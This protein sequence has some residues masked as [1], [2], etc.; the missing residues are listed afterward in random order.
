VFDLSY[1]LDAAGRFTEALPYALK[2]AELS[3]T[4]YALDAAAAHYR[5]AGRGVTEDDAATRVVVAEGLGDVLTLQGVYSEAEEQYVL[6]RS[7]VQERAAAASIDAKLGALAFKQADIATARQHLE[8][9]LERLGRRIPRSTPA[10]VL[11]LLWEAMVQAAHS[12]APKLLLGRR[13]PAGREVD[14]LAMRIYSRLAYLYWFYSGRTT[15]AWTHLR[16]LNLAERYPPSPELAQAYS[17]HAPVMTML[18]WFSRGLRYARRS[19]EIRHSYGDTWGKGQSLGFLAVVEYNAS[20]FDDAIASCNEAIRLLRQTGDQWEVNTATWH[21]ALCHWRK[22]ELA[23]AAHVARELFYS[24]REIGDRTAAG[25][26]LSIWTRVSDGHLD[27][28]LLEEQIRASDGD[29]AQTTAELYLA[30]ALHARANGDLQAALD[31]LEQAAGVV[32]SAK[33]RQEYIAP[34]Y[35]WIATVRREL[36]ERAPLH[37]P[38]LRESFLRRA[39]RSARVARRW[40]RSYR[41]N[42][43][44][45]LRESALIASERGRCRRARRWMDASVAV[46]VAQGARYEAAL[47]ESIRAELCASWG[48]SSEVRPHDADSTAPDAVAS[49]SEDDEVPTISLFDRFSALLKAGR[50]ITAAASY[51]ALEAA[52]REA[53]LALLRAERCHLVPLVALAD[54]RVTTQSGEDLYGMSRSL[55]QRAVEE[56]APVV[57]VEQMADSQDSLLLSGIRSAIAAPIMVGGEPTTCLYATHRQVGRLFGDEEIQLASFIATLAGA[58]LEH[59]AGSE[60]RFRSLAQN[61]SDVITLVDRDGVVSYQSSAVKRVFAMAPTTLLGKPVTEWV[62]PDDLEAF[63]AALR[64]AGKADDTRIECRFRHADGSFRVAET[65]VTNLL[66]EPTVAALVLNTRDVTD[67]RRAEEQLREKNVELEKASRAKDMFLASMSHELRT[68]LNAIIGF[69]GTLL[70]ELPGPLNSEQGRQLRTVQHSGKHLL[71]IINDLLDLAKIESG[72]VALNLEPVDAAQVVHRVLTTLQPLADAKSLPLV[73]ELPGTPLIVRS[74]A[75]ALGQIL[76]NLVN[77]AI[78]F[79]EQGE[80]RVRLERT[81][82]QGARVTVTDTGP[83]IEPDDLS[84]IFNAFERGPERKVIRSAEGT[85]LGLHISQ[86]LVELIDADITV[87]TTPGAGSTFTVVLPEEA[88]A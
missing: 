3:R 17:E 33:L 86:K 4:R 83:G 72:A 24:A 34:I 84:R 32:R 88:A 46:A 40:A 56:G 61:S 78:K 45:A 26:A 71:A 70:M 8:G 5:I 10:Q 16:G 22:G 30:R 31:Y 87:E 28:A 9:A 29:D 53:A 42:A 68:P 44:Q 15:C 82:A 51:P 55:V 12:I 11:F 48:V 62:H 2:A 85:G 67:R 1:H 52:I 18:P 73:A 20:R 79:T 43:P 36:S 6:A 77:N 76:I 14:F 57:A 54:E 49:I 25:I 69:T 50:A 80:V 58:A 37:N 41:N 74:D 75:R 39:A 19:Y 81:P 47:S 66:Q 38:R 27:G 13:S 23:E 59:L 65:T 60:N 63:R 35:P 21:L 7:L 64:S